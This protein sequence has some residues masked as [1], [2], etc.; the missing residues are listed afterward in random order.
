[1][2][3]H[4]YVIQSRFEL[5]SKSYIFMESDKLI[6]LTNLFKHLLPAE[7]LSE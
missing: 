1:M 7:I 2:D 4:P 6:P 3:M 5:S